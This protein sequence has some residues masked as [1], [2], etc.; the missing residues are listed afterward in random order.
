MEENAGKE[1]KSEEKG[2]WRRGEKASGG[3]KM[4]VLSKFFGVPRKGSWRGVIKRGK[5]RKMELRGCGTNCCHKGSQ[6]L[7]G[8]DTLIP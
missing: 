5:R 6:T 4:A 7:A 8:I 1:R 3:P 2:C